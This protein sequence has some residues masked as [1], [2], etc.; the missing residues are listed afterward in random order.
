MTYLRLPKPFR[1][2]EIERLERAC[3]RP[4][5]W[6]ACIF[7]RETGLRA[8]EALA[9]SR[10]EAETWFDDGP[11]WIRRPREPK[12]LRLVG[13][14]NKERVVV[15]SEAAIRAARVLLDHEPRRPDYRTAWR[16]TM[17]FPWA[18]RR[19]RGVMT[20]LGERAGVNCHPHRWRHTHAQELVD[21][22]ASIQVVADMLGHT[23]LDT[24]RLYFAASP[25]AKAEAMVG[26]RRFLRR[27]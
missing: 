2:D 26:R 6:A 14:G 21:S 11:T 24:T 4:E 25:T 16:R 12:T 8:H 5:V 23:K 13:K 3:E 17:L 1:S 7:L 10:E 20:E 15:L 9:I 22:G 18:D 27:R 19:L